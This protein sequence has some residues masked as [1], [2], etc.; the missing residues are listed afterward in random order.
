MPRFSGPPV[1]AA[2]QG[3]CTSQYRAICWFLANADNNDARANLRQ[4]A[5]ATVRAFLAGFREAL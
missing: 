2:E 4:E 3:R 1:P 5:V